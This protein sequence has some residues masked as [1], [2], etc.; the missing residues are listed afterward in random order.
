MIV[1]PCYGQQSDAVDNLQ[2]DNANNGELDNKTEDLSNDNENKE[3]KPRKT[4]FKEERFEKLFN[5][6]LRKPRLPAP[7]YHQKPKPKLPSFIKNPPSVK[8]LG[9]DGLP[10]DDLPRPTTPNPRAKQ[11]SNNAR[12]NV[13]KTTTSAPRTR[14]RASTTTTVRPSVNDKRFS[15][16]S[17]GRISNSSSNSIPSSGRSRLN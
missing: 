6:R 8:P 9:Q 16:S 1:L 11:Q 15:S 4:T 13:S 7:K 3:S 14:N 12:A 2:G 17:R 5:N 10:I